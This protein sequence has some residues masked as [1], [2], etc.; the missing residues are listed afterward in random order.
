[1]K[2][3]V[4]LMTLV[5]GQL[6]FAQ[7]DLESQFISARSESTG[8]GNSGDEISQEF[9]SYATE[10]M[11]AISNNP[12][13]E[14]FESEMKE[15]FLAIESTK[16]FTVDFNLCWEENPNC[17]QAESLVS[18]NYPDEKIILV[19]RNRFTNLE[20]LRM[21]HLHSI[22]EF[23]GIAR[24][25]ENNYAFSSKFLDAA[26]Y[27]REGKAQKNKAQSVV[28]TSND[29]KW[30]VSLDTT[31]KD[32]YGTANMSTRRYF[33]DE[34][35]KDKKYKSKGSIKTPY[36]NFNNLKVK[37]NS[38]KIMQVLLPSRMKIDQINFGAS[39][40]RFASSIKIQT[41]DYV[42]GKAIVG[43]KK[44]PK[45]FPVFRKKKDTDFSEY[46]IYMN[47]IFKNHIN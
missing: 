38:T 39:K 23:A 28:C 42:L 41:V 21:K 9:T 5:L 46:G 37:E 22:H 27:Y 29:G 14:L 16:I 2:R 33:Q 43:V 47:C 36:E 7:L 45:V 12:S 34:E 44:G 18:K 24:I 6:S 8:A 26:N 4:I 19:N 30:E 40:K 11:N 17:N 13:S 3:M 25:E 31:G 15:I 20:S 1:M 35:L 32:F 10:V